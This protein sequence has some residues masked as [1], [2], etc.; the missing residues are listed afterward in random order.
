[1]V[2]RIDG[3]TGA[4]TKRGM[5]TACWV[6]IVSLGIAACG[7]KANVGG[8]HVDEDTDSDTDSVTESESESGSGSESD[9]GT[10]SESGTD[11]GPC[12][13]DYSDPIQTVLF[14]E[15]F[16]NVT[17]DQ[18][19][20]RNDGIVEQALTGWVVATSPE[21][22]YPFPAGF[23][24]QALDFVVLHWT[25]IDVCDLDDEACGLG[26]FAND[27]TSGGGDL[28]LL[29]GD[30]LDCENAVVDYVHWGD[31]EPV[32]NDLG[33][34]ASEAGEWPA[35]DSVDVSTYAPG[36]SL[37]HD[38]THENGRTHWY[39]DGAPTLGDPNF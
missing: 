39:I 2:T 14:N 34:I 1:M 35:G 29:R 6:G 20:L 37:I 5:T 30:D 22:V 38:A 16:F 32:E 10:G 4:R 19:E 15:I 28:L 3:T 7:G 21:H 18:V 11:V 33:P 13:R 17:D 27:L 25:P 12:D 36:L 8:L 26:G 9:T 31:E 24:I 23:T